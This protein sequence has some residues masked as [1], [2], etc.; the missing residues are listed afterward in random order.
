MYKRQVYNYTLGLQGSFTIE[1][2]IDSWLFGATYSKSKYNYNGINDP[3]MDEMVQ[4]QR[5]ETDPA[6]RREL[7]RQIIRYMTE[8]VYVIGIANSAKYEF[9]QPYLKNYRPN[10]GSLGLPVYESWVEK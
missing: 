10:V 1:A 6:K 9:W 4:Q 5:R 2:D 7:L 8:N 3:R